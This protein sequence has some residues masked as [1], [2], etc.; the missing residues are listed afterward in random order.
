MADES[1]KGVNPNWNDEAKVAFNNFR[2]CKRSLP[3]PTDTNQSNDPN[4]KKRKGNFRNFR[5]NAQSAIRT[6]LFDKNRVISNDL[7]ETRDEST[8][9]SST[10]SE[11]HMSIEECDE[12]EL[13]RTEVMCDD[14]E[15]NIAVVREMIRNKADTYAILEKLTDDF[16][17]YYKKSREMIHKLNVDHA[18]RL[19]RLNNQM[20]TLENNL[21]DK[22]NVISDRTE[23]RVNAIEVSQKCAK[24]NNM[25]WISFTDPKEIECLRLKNKSELMREAKQIFARMNIWLNSMDRQ[26]FDVMI[27]K[28]SVKV[29]KGFAN[30]TIMGVRFMNHVTVQNLKR[31]V[32]DYAKKQFMAKNFDAVRYTVR[33]NWSPMIWKMLRVCYDLSSFNLIENA[34]VCESGIQVTYKSYESSM[35]GEEKKEVLIKSL[36]RT[37]GDLDRLRMNIGDA[38][39]DLPTFRVYDGNYF[40]LGPI[41]RKSYKENLAKNST[42]LSPVSRQQELEACSSK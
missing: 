4:N 13:D 2:K 19:C 30:E 6:E 17:D 34:H 35:N 31:L 33:D 10:F 41:E 12:S 8:I 25:I 32:M 36:I 40:K 38:G 23:E 11:L 37:E 21:Y 29:D 1:A 9:K 3:S 22:I 39:C 42:Q 16:A 27:Q 28:V 5:F 15:K 24:E 18:T 7:N 20:V 26:I 14:I